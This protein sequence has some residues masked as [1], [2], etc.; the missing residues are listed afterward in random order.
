MKLR[1]VKRFIP[2]TSNLEVITQYFETDGINERWIDF[3]KDEDAEWETPEDKIK[4]DNL[5]SWK[6]GCPI[7]S[8][9]RRMI[10]ER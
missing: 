7:C 10:H 5:N 2:G 3:P 1:K 4:F 6:C 9:A 8:M